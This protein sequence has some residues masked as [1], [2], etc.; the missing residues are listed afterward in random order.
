MALKLLENEDYENALLTFKSIYDYK[1]SKKYI[2]NF[3]VEAEKVTT[4]YYEE[5]DECVHNDT[6]R[7]STTKKFFD[8]SGNV[9]RKEVCFTSISGE[10][11]N[12]STEY[13][14]DNDGNCVK[15]TNDD[16]IGNTLKKEYIYDDKN[17]LIKQL[18]IGYGIDPGYEYVYEYDI[19]N[20][21]TKVTNKDK[22]GNS[23]VAEYKYDESGNC[24]KIVN[25]GTYDGFPY[26]IQFEYTYNGQGTLIK[27][28]ELY[29]GGSSSMSTI[30][31]SYDKTGN[32]VKE[33]SEGDETYEIVNEYDKY[34]NCVRSIKYR[35]DDIREITDTTYTGIH[36]RYVEDLPQKK[37][38]NEFLGIE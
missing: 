21:C 11:R 22:S 33:V 36:V 9:A 32:C 14:Y 6:W 25:N 1:D 7:S 4:S 3:V 5:S 19:Y 20:N 26:E 12:S 18:G 15:E 17:K 34:G 35:N 27:K 24:I 30:E 37:L 23:F 31:Y 38:M 2:D 13:E 29:G 10:E 8:E 28:K 16:L